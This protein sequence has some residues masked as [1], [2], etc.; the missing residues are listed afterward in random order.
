MNPEIILDKLIGFFSPK[1][2]FQRTQYRNGV[3]ALYEAGQPRR[4]GG[5]MRPDNSSGDLLTLRAQGNIRGYARQLS[6]NHDLA[7]AILDTLV[8]NVVGSNGINVEPMPRRKNG[9]LH[10]EFAAKLLDLWTDFKENPEVTWEHE[11][12]ECERLMCLAWMRDGEAFLQ[13]LEGDII[14][15]DHGTKVPLSV[16]MI[17]ADYLPFWFRDAGL[18]IEQ[19]IERNGWGKARAY[20]VL[21]NHPQDV[22]YSSGYTDMRRIPAEKMAHLKLTQRF[23]QSRGVSVFATIMSRLEDIKDYEESERIAAR[24]A[25]AMCAFIKRG[26]PDDYDPTNNK[27]DREFK[28]APGMIFNNLAAGEDIGMINSNRPNPELGNFRNTQL[29]AACAGAGV[30]YPSVSKDFS[31][32][33]IGLRLSVV[34]ADANYSTLTNIFIG[35]TTKK[36]YKKFVKMAV[37]SGQLVIPSDLDINTLD[38]AE[39]YG[40]KMPSV[41]P[42][43]EGRANIEAEAAGH[44]SPQQTI[45]AN[46]GNPDAVYEQ[47]KTWQKRAEGDGI[48]FSTFK[49]D[50]PQPTSYSAETSG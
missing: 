18:G 24:V 35:K 6:Q 50:N 8:N 33:Y 7:K 2:E 45:R 36:V 44:R 20:H 9:E 11:W 12:P 43:K 29:K 34:D 48:M 14:G 16:E 30:N 31:G 19:S 17:E 26:N 3:K 47:I 23:R 25:A 39:Y 49:S 38:K 1:G 40:P 13:F 21:K 27:E 22:S 5:K 32:T 10:T 46:G 28:L 41:D 37:L 4:N 42:L 15:L